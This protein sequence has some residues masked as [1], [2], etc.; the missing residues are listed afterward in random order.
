MQIVSYVRVFRL[1]PVFCNYKQVCNES[2]HACVFSYCWRYTFRVNSQTQ[3]C[4]VKMNASVFLLDIAR[5]PFKRVVPVCIPNPMQ[6]SA[7]FHGTS[8][9][10]CVVNFL[11][12]TSLIVSQCT[13]SFF[14]FICLR[15]IYKLPFTMNFLFISFAQFWLFFT[16]FLRVF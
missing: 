15:S 12:F 13:N 14:N 3:D 4:W 10:R 8:P 5:H 11:I 6:K 2:S 1:F 9:M 16:Q 7:S